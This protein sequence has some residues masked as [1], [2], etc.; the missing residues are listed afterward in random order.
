LQRQ[1]LNQDFPLSWLFHQCDLKGTYMSRTDTNGLGLS[2][3]SMRWLEVLLVRLTIVGGDE[4]FRSMS[5]IKE[6]TY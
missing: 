5:L 2:G 4:G 6:M 3:L 1:V